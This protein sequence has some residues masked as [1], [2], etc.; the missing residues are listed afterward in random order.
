MSATWELA[1]SI[2]ALI[3]NCH[4][5]KGKRFRPRDFNPLEKRANVV[6]G[7]QARDWLKRKLNG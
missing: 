4:T 6:S 7:D 5:T 2:C 1:S 3:A